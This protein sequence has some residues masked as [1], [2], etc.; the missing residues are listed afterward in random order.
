MSKNWG[1]WGEAATGYPNPAGD[2][3]ET[4][5]T[6]AQQGDVN[7]PEAGAG[8]SAGHPGVVDQADVDNQAEAAASHTTAAGAAAAAVG[9]NGPPCDFGEKLGEMN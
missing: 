1:L 7:Q 8:A 3:A 9:G 2:V 6:K 5:Q 4:G